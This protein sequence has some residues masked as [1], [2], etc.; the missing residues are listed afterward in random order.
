M[1]SSIDHTDTSF[2]SES[3]SSVLMSDLY[4]SLGWHASSA[5][6]QDFALD[7]LFSEPDDTSHQESYNAS[8]DHPPPPAESHSNQESDDPTTTGDNSS[9]SL[10]AESTTSA[11]ASST[12]VSSPASGS[13]PRGPSEVEAMLLFLRERRQPQG[14][15]IAPA[16]ASLLL[17]PLSTPSVSSS[18]GG[19]PSLQ[20]RSPL[21]PVLHLGGYDRDAL[22]GNLQDF[23]LLEPPPIIHPETIATASDSC[24]HSDIDE[25]PFEEDSGPGHCSSDCSFL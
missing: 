10:N 8:G 24:L 12:S 23:A 16:I 20:P 19:M 21:P 5:Q 13:Q 17:P 14:T 9:S 2:A 25:H 3:T 18:A 4:H 15:V 22:I 11:E 7:V 1:D 6:G